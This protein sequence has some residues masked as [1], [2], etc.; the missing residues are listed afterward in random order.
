MAFKTS[1]LFALVLALKGV[2]AKTSPNEFFTSIL[3]IYAFIGSVIV[4]NVKG[5]IPAEK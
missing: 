3:T 2:T 4:S 1:I 5:N